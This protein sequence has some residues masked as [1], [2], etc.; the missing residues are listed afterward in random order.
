M[1]CSEEKNA[2]YRFSLVFLGG[3]VCAFV[4]GV[5]LSANTNAQPSTSV[6]ATICASSSSVTIT[7]PMSDSVIVDPTVAIRG[8]V[9]QASQI[10][11]LVDGVYDGVIPLDVGQSTYE[12]QVQ[13]S[14]GTH[15]ITLK[16][17]DYCQSAD[18]V[19]TTVVT[20]TPPPGSS[21]VG[22]ETETI[23][24]DG[25]D[26]PQGVVIGGQ[27]GEAPELS[28]KNPLL[29]AI[30]VEPLQ[31]ILRWLNIASYDSSTTTHSQ[32][33]LPRAVAIGV[34]AYVLLFGLAANV[35]KMIAT[36]PMLSAYSTKRRL[37]IVSRVARIA[38]AVLLLAGLLL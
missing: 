20:Y 4:L 11:V 32:L 27:T 24:G 25:D 7:Q 8:T 21:S 31:D 6:N 35:I 5:L 9:T 10:E 23:A 2:K 33:S 14:T 1:L 17:I 22:D 30:I 37:E 28:Q 12:S 26:R 19:A 16:A 3:I 36:L 18:S 38:G 15:T 29:P 13:L 34:G